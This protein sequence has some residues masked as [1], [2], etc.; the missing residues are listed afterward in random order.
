MLS[1]RN[2][3]RKQGFAA[4]LEAAAPLLGN[5]DGQT[6]DRKITEYSQQMAF[7]RTWEI[8]ATTVTFPTLEFMCGPGGSTATAS[9]LYACNTRA[10]DHCPIDAPDPRPFHWV[11]IRTHVTASS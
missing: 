10:V 9:P 5:T 6:E 4:D 8:R 2:I 3:S 11:L 7:L 1:I